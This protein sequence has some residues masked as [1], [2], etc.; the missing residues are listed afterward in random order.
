[1]QMP[2]INLDDIKFTREKFLQLMA[3]AHG[4]PNCERW[5]TYTVRFKRVP[6]GAILLDKEDLAVDHPPA[7]LARSRVSET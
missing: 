5:L 3:I 6:G 4:G 7:T 2:S 1:M